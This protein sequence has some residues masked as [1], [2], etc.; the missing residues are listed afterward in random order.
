VL[1]LVVALILLMWACSRT[2][3]ASTEAGVA[4]RRTWGQIVT[5]AARSLRCDPRVY[6][7]IG[8]VFVPLGALAALL[9]WLLFASP[10]DS[11]VREAGERNAFVAAIAIVLGVAVALLGFVLVQAATAHVLV[12]LDAGRTVTAVSAYRTVLHRLRPLVTALA[13]SAAAQVALDVTIVL[14]PVG[15]YL[16]VRWSLMGVI[17]GVEPR[18]DPGVLRRSAALTGRA[19]LR[20]ASVTIGVTGAAL[21]AGPLLGVLLLVTTGVSFALVNVI[22]ALVYVV[23]LPFVALVATYLYFDLRERRQ[24]APAGIPAPVEGS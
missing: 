2:E 10:L 21:L 17:V 6:L 15:F 18:S 8:T 7:A 22:A 9:Q 11:L 1:G 24:P 20:T 13:A 14:I 23:A 5:A 4:R 3:W 16:L 12:E 19:F